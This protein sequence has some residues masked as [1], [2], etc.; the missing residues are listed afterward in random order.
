MCA[1]DQTT[2]SDDLL[3][4]ARDCFCFVTKFF[5]LI[6]LSAVHIYC[7]A[8]ELCPLSSTVRMLYYHQ[9]HTTFPRVVAGAPESW[10]EGVSISS[11]YKSESFTWSPCGQFIATCVGAAVEI[12][13]ALSSELVSSF[14]KPD[15]L[16]EHGL[17]YSPDGQSLA[18]LSNTLIIWDTQT[19]GPVEEIQCGTSTDGSVAW[20]LDG[21]MIGITKGSTI[22]VYDI[23]L[24]STWTPGT[25]QSSSKLHLWPHGKTFQILVTGLEGTVFTL[26]IFE[27][28][29]GLT[30]IESFHIKSWRWCSEIAS[31]SPATYRISILGFNRFHILDIQNSGHLL[32]EKGNFK[33]HCFSSDGSLFAA[34]L[35][36][37]VVH[38]W[39]YNS[40]HYTNWRVFSTQSRKIYNSFPLQLSPTSPSILGRFKGILQVYH[41][42]SLPI[43][44][45]PNYSTPRVVLSPCGT[46]MVTAC[47]GGSTI[48]ITNLLSQIAP[49]FIDTDMEIDT[50]AITGNVLSVLSPRAITAWRL[51]DEGLVGG[52]FR[53]QRAGHGNSIWTV[54]VFSHPKF[55]LKGQ[56]VTIKAGGGNVIHVYHSGTG[57]ALQAT[58]TPPDSHTHCY[59][60]FQMS[61]GKHYLH[62]HRLAEQVVLSEENWPVSVATLQEGWVKDPEGKHRLWMPIEWRVPA[63]SSGAWLSNI[64]TLWLNLLSETVII[65]F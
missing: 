30:K 28:G 12:R 61:F 21:R 9:R 37:S 14:T 32:E 25:L 48:T 38:V 6:N 39:K 20:S 46:Y 49:Q 17:A 53:D 29:L 33:S 62:Y 41:L 22:H 59:D 2:K 63:P 27:V 65:M 45:H 47:K 7:S 54:Q 31:F 35:D 43:T 36:E 13:D 57:E 8:L 10:G 40:G 5:E 52:V 64:T 56:T 42:D 11:K 26:T 55:M 1:M 16:C 23:A 3:N 58:Q 15:A 50:L 24:N 19:G 51:T 4:T 34:S 44:A 60:H 18:Y